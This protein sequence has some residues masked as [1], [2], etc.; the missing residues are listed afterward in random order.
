MK[1]GV[2]GPTDKWTC[3]RTYSGPKTR[4]RTSLFSPAIETRPTRLRQ[5]FFPETIT[6][7]LGPETCTLTTRIKRSSVIPDGSSCFRD[8]LWGSPPCITLTHPSFTTV[9]RHNDRQ[10]PIYTVS[11]SKTRQT[12]DIF[13]LCLPGWILD[14]S[15]LCTCIL[16]VESLGG[17][18]DKRSRYITLRYN[19]SPIEYQLFKFETDTLH[20]RETRYHSNTWTSSES[21]KTIYLDDNRGVFQY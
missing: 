18:D 3:S 19:V 13:E 5:D 8:L 7:T 10:H 21:M 2:G 11:E 12:T 1:S 16:P 17:D 4:E 6:S 20:D 14:H 15:L 9:C